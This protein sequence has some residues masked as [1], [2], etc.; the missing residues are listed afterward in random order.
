VY[1]E[2]L[3]LAGVVLVATEN[4]SLYAFNAASGRALWRTHLATPVAGGQ[5]PCGDIDPSG[6]TSTPV[7]DASAGVLYAVALQAG[8]RH[9]LYALSVTTGRV[10]WSRDVDL[11]GA[12]PLVEQQRSALALA[13]GRVFVAYGGLYGDCGSYHGWVMGAPSAGPAGAVISYQVPTGNQ[14]GI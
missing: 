1:A 10:L 8:F 5:L 3:V 7:A 14:G 2:P 11:T 13:N 6:I 12:D 4:G 9:V